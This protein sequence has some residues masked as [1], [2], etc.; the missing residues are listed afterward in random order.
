MKEK[1]IVSV[2]TVCYNAEKTISNTFNSILKQEGFKS[3]DLIIVDGKSTDATNDIIKS[4]LDFF[5][6]KN[7]SVTYI[8]EKDSGVYDAMN[9][10]VSLAHGDWL[11]F[12]NA[13]DCFA[14]AFVLHDIF[15]NCLDLSED[16]IYGDTICKSEEK[17]KILKAK[18][19][20]RLKVYKP[21]VHQ[22]CF[23]KREVQKRFPF[24][25]NYKISADYDFFLRIFLKNYRFK[26]VNR[27]ISIFSESGMSCNEANKKLIRKEESKIAKNYGINFLNT[28]SL[29]WY[30]YVKTFLRATKKFILRNK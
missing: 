29:V 18:N 25:L 28:P 20:N 13:D 22:S 8:S 10:A 4:Y 5:Q 3:F 7:I 24:D 30:R 27:T 15:G 17:E 19:V 12:M 1:P 6:E 2:V 21:F 23:V 11:I 9:K 14:D 26:Y 16:V